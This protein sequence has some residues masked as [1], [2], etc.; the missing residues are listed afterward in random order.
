M[1]L[2]TVGADSILGDYL[3]WKVKQ[4]TTLDGKVIGLPIDIGPT[5]LYYR[6]DVF[7]AGRSAER[8]GQGGRA[9]EDL[10]RLLR[11]RRRS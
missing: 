10:G 5:A 1:D 8:P 2:K 4:A 3:D 9:A 6:E 7:A 11:R